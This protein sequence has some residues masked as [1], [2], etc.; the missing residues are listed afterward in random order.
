MAQI[1]FGKEFR[2]GC[3]FLLIFLIYNC[4]PYVDGMTEDAKKTK[5]KQDCDTL[6]QAIEKHNSLEG[7]AVSTKDMLEL[8]GKY[9]TNLT[10]VKDPWGNNY[11][12]DRL[13]G[14]VYSKGPDKKHD[15]NDPDSADNKDDINVSY[16]SSP[17]IKK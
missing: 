2:I 7:Y 15:P 3:G 13:R 11:E 17:G 1:M 8:Q 5:A 9:I 4:M 16:I 6:C 10:A 12:H 14:R